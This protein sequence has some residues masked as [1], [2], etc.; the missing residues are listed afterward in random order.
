ML[1]PLLLLDPPSVA[2]A[3]AYRVARIGAAAQLARPSNCNAT[4]A[5][6]AY[7]PP[8]YA[9]AEGALRFPWESALSGT[10]VQYTGGH[11]SQ[12]GRYEQHISA[13]IALACRDY[14]RTTYNK[15]WLKAEGYPI[16]RGTAAFYHAR[17]AVPREPPAHADRAVQGR[18]DGSNGTAAATLE[19]APALLT[20]A[21]VMGPDE[22]NYRACL[23]GR[24]AARARVLPLLLL[25]HAR[26]CVCVGI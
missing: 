24:Q 6:P 1:P 17:C 9:P 13:D 8:G 3:L 16:I 2:S 7:C 23:R 14:Y 21:N 4:R 15:T 18:V 22:Y 12:Y 10:E 26:V 20:C 11:T 25:S 19:D 5:A